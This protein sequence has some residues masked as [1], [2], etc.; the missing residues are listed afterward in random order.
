MIIAQISDTHILSKSSQLPEGASRVDDLRRC[1]FDINRDGVDAVVHTGDTVH[2]GLPEEYEHLREIL[3]ELSSPFF[4]VPGNRDRHA[5]LREYFSDL[6]YLPKTGDFLQYTLENSSLRLVVLDSV[7][8]GERKGVFCKQRLKWLDETLSKQ[9][10]QPT[11]LFIHHPPF[12]IE[13]H[14]VSGYREQKE[15]DDLT[16]MVRRHPQVKGLLCGHVHRLHRELW[17]G[18]VAS[19]MPS[20]A[21]DLRKGVATEI[22]KKPFYVVHEVSDTGELVTHRKVVSD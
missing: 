4:L 5:V 7:Q 3:S 16:A 2:Q 10:N 14:Y 13:P 20:V 19:T 9:T 17:A 12:D 11:L 6:S 22:G 21:V 15:A 8:D 18:T 1:I